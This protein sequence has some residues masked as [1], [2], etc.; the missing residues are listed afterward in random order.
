MKRIISLILVAVLVTICAGSLAGCVYDDGEGLSVVVTIFPQ[1][2][3]V[4][5]IVGDDSQIEVTLLLDN[6]TDLHSY[7][8]TFGDLLAIQSCDL[9][10]YVGG[11]SDEWVED[12]LANPTNSNRQVINL[13]EVLGDSA[14]VE[15]SVEGMEEEHEHEEEE[16]EHEEEYDEHV[17]LSLVNAQL[18]CNKIAE[19]LGVIDTANAEK[20][21]ANATAYNAQLNSLHLQYKTEL[22]ETAKDTVVVCDRF[23]FRYLVDDYGI[24][25]FAAFAGCSTESNATFETIFFLAGKVDELQVKYVIVLEG[26]ATSI[27]NS[28]IQN[29][30]SENVGT[31][32][33]NSMQSITSTDIAYGANYLSIMQTNLQTLKQALQ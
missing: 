4:K 28:V 32:S 13:M 18:F 21:T 14:K 30:N 11:E 8:P 10:I 22:A 6:G 12:A 33:L 27:A 16:H 26:T 25:Y 15:E 23:P 24:N 2:D 29:A 9:F 20:Y 31:L 5:Q 1:Y 17:W 3:W 19:K 7:S